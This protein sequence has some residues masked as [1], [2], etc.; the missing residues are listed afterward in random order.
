MLPREFSVSPSVAQ[1]FGAG[2]S[3]TGFAVN[4]DG[5]ERP[6][7]AYQGVGKYMGLRGMELLKGSLWLT[8]VWRKFETE[9]TVDPLAGNSLQHRPF[10]RSSL[11]RS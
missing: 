2:F 3:E 1:V 8:V 7:E 6:L 10:K 4:P 11:F 5:T 9:G